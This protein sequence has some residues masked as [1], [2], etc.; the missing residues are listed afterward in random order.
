MLQIAVIDGQGG[1]IG[2][3]V[4]EQLRRELE[5]EVRIIAVGTNVHAT[6]AMVKAG[7]D[8]GATGENAVVYNAANCDVIVAPIGLIFANSMFGEVSPAMARAISESRACKVLI[9]VSKCNAYVAGITE[10]PLSGYIEE[11]VKFLRL[12]CS[13]QEKNYKGSK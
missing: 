13:E 9:P 11:A 10:R 8:A 2:K 12:R 7:A 1:G 6:S 4:V 3:T 5:R